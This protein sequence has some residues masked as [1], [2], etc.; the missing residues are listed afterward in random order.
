MDLKIIFINLMKKY[1]N[2]NQYIDMCWSEI[3]MKYSD[4]SRY[5]HTSKHLQ[6]MMNE[7]SQFRNEIENL[8]AF[9][10]ALY[11]H[12]IIYN[13][14][15]TDNEH[16]S[17]ILFENRIGSTTFPNI[18]KSV[19][20]IESTKKHRFSTDN[21]INIFL[22]LDLLIL[23]KSKSEY[24]EYCRNV[25]HEYIMIPE[26]NYREG[27]KKVIQSFLDQPNIYKTAHCLQHYESNAY[28]NLTI[29]LEMLQL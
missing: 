27:R 14:L 5:Y 23:G 10:F 22:D 2:D 15:Q 26:E 11:Y 16:Q 18:S 20:I 8:D 24:L 7:V 1:C 3:E 4:K 13:P 25:R 29:E 6:T 28:S 12:D 19:E 9:L 21:D 17:A